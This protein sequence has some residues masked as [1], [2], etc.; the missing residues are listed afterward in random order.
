MDDNINRQKTILRVKSELKKN[1][2]SFQVSFLKNQILKSNLKIN[3]TG[4][5]VESYSTWEN[6]R[7]M[8]NN[9]FFQR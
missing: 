2:F 7:E 5:L 3:E 4:L 6:K 8:E 1:N 9:I